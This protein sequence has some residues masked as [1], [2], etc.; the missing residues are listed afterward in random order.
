MR[1]VT[2]RT[3]KPKQFNY[4]PRFYDVEK[5]ELE[6]KKA[7]LGLDSTLSHRENL[8]MQMARRWHRGRKDE[9]RSRNSLMLS[10][11]IY[12]VIILGGIYL[13]FFTDFVEKLVAVFS[14]SR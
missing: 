5:E 14:A 4:R 8:R 6:Q 9:G 10:Y 1:F 13:L 12:A 7:A 2:F 11:T 3:P